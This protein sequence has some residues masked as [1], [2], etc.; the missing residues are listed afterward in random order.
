[1]NPLV[2]PILKA[3]CFSILN[4][5]NNHEDDWGKPALVDTFTRLDGIKLTYTGGGVNFKAAS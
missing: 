5:A 2:L 3:K 4:V 1:M